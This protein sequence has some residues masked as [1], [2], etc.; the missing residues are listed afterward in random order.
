MEAKS[1][2]PAEV[3]VVEP[4]PAAPADNPGKLSNITIWQAAGTLGVGTVLVML[5]VPKMMARDDKNQTFIQEKLVTTLELTAQRQAEANILSQ[6]QI[7]ATTQQTAAMQMQAAGFN[8][9]LPEIKALTTKMTPLVSRLE[10]TAD[11]I[12]GI[13]EGVKADAERAEA[14]NP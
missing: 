6:A 8:A 12:E 3:F 11:G 4:K 13:W 2:K 1:D 9:M 14:E 5:I 10:R 7:A